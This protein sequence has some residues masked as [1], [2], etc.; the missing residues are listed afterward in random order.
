MK[1]MIFLIFA[2]LALMLCA[3]AF[4]DPAATDG[5]VTVWIGEENA[6]FMKCTDGVTRKLSAPM[7]DILK[8]TQTE[9]VGLTQA[10]QIVAVKK[11]GSG[12]SVLAENATDG[13]IAAQRDS[14]FLL[15]DSGKLSAGTVV[16]SERAAAAATDGL[17]LYWVNRGDNGYILMHGGGP[18][19]CFRQPGKRG[20]TD[21]PGLRAGNSRGVHGGRQA[22][23]VQYDPP[24]SVDAG[25]HSE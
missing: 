20:S 23:P 19:H 18:E 16:Y 7:K 9:A 2:V 11:D 21:L 10:N 17:I 15:E 24:A 4:A 1:R 8:L 22:V 3:G 25:N 6:L 5:T 14:R 13:E 12:Y